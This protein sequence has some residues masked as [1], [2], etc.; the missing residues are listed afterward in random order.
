MTPQQIKNKID[1]LSFWL[2]HNPSHPDYQIVL[3]DKL[4]LERK[5]LLK[6]D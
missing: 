4:S 5:H 1:E 2:I 6:N 3:K